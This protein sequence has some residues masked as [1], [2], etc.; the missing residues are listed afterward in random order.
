[1]G[2]T[3]T[4]NDS[5]A[6]ESRYVGWPPSPCVLRVTGIDR[7]TTKV[8]RVSNK[9]RAGGGKLVFY[10]KAGGPAKKTLKL[11]VAALGGSVRFWVGGEFGNA[12]PHSS[13][14]S[15]TA[16]ASVVP[17]DIR[18]AGSR[19]FPAIERPSRCARGSEH[20]ARA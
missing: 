14:P 12:A 19:H 8:V 1:M 4:I 17:H 20:S 18:A 2:F 5:R 15:V 3:P 11:N 6:P 16:T 7:L 10:E 9:A 13:R